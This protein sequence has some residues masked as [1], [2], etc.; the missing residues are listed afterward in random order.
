MSRSSDEHVETAGRDRECHFCG[1]TCGRGRRFETLRATWVIAFS[2][3][4][5]IEAFYVC[6]KKDQQAVVWMA[7]ESVDRAA[8]AGSACSRDQGTRSC[9]AFIVL[10][11]VTSLGGMLVCPRRLGWRRSS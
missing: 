5:G 9:S 3:P 4:L 6:W 11:L 2:E 7:A 8:L 1:L 10:I